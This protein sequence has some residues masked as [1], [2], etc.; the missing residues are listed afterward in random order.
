M[1]P[2]LF[3]FMRYFSTK[4]DKNSKRSLTPEKFLLIED[5]PVARTGIQIYGAHEILNSKGQ[6]IFEGDSRGI[7]YIDRPEEEVFRPETLASFN[8]KPIVN[9]HPPEGQ[10]VD[11]DNFNSFSVGVV[12]NPQRGKGEWDQWMV[13]DLL[14]TNRQAINDVDSGK[15]EVSCGYAPEY[16]KEDES[17]GYQKNIIG[18]HIAIVEHGRCGETC[19]IG[20]SDSDPSGDD[21]MAKKS[22]FERLRC[23]R[24]SGDAKKLDEVLKEMPATDAEAVVTHD[25]ADEGGHHVEQHFHLA[26]TPGNAGSVTPPGDAKWN[27]KALDEK[28]KSLDDC[29]AD[30]RKT[31]D[32]SHKAV[33]DAI[34]NL[35]GKLPKPGETTVTPPA[36]DAETREI[37]GELKEEAPVGTGDAALKGVKDSALFYDSF[38]ET[39]S[40]AEIIAP[41]MAVPTFDAKAAPKSTLDSLCDLRRKALGFALNEPVGAAMI[42]GARGGR[43]LDAEGLKTLDCKSLRSL[44]NAVGAQKRL[45]N[46]AR[47][48]NSV[49]TTIPQTPMGAWSPADINKR[50]RQHYSQTATR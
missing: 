2:S 14:I 18:N 26:G 11:P 32:E 22:W 4:I 20:D 27:E 28:F 13:A 50:N 48:A 8:G 45:A 46:N 35:E 47:P 34:A 39:I 49:D 10:D 38:Q 29:M 9:G 5:V 17:H 33:M 37:E 31:H 15:V 25:A 19:A 21:D 43:A 16:V 40:T 24:S 41:G 30:F 3:Y 6:Q 36:G 7:V 23:A 12:L 44:F 42:Q 1:P